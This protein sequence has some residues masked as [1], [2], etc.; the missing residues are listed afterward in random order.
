[1]LL[2]SNF[3]GE[4]PVP[5][6]S[7]GGVGQNGHH[8]MAGNV[9]EWCLKGRKRTRSTGRVDRAQHSFTHNFARSPMERHPDMGF[10]CAVFPEPL[11]ENPTAAVEAGRR[12]F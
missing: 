8:D 6:G 4:G 10:R 12:D 9:N 11:D 1:M 5:A 2:R 3:N 7:L